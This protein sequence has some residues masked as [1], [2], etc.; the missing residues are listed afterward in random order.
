MNTRDILSW[1]W[2]SNHNNADKSGEFSVKLYM[3]LSC[4]AG[5]DV[6]IPACN[7]NYDFIR[8][9]GVVPVN[10]C[11]WGNHSAGVDVV[12]LCGSVSF[13]YVNN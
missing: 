4:K 6:T 3:Y 9:N 10:D 8:D 13:F 2:Y 7:E 1:L 5:K 12:K 11:T